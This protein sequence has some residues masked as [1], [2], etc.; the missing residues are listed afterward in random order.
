MTGV[1]I[2]G[3]SGTVSGNDSHLIELNNCDG[4]EYSKNSIYADALH[5]NDVKNSS[6]TNNFHS[7]DGGIGLFVKQE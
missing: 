5:L 6:F 1:S 2:T 3:N 7:S 4:L